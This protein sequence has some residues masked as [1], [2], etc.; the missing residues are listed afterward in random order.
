MIAWEEQELADPELE[1]LRVALLFPKGRERTTESFLGLLR[2]G[3]TSAVCVAFD[4]YRHCEVMTRHGGEN[5]LTV[6]KDEVLE[7]AR[8]ILASATAEEEHSVVALSVLGF[9][10]G[11]QDTELIRAALESAGTEEALI[12]AV[13]AADTIL[14][15]GGSDSTQ[16]KSLTAAVARPAFD[17]NR[18]EAVRWL[19]LNAVA[20]GP[21]L[22]AQEYLLQALELPSITLQAVAGLALAQHDSTAHRPMLEAMVAGWPED[23]DFPA[24]RLLSLL[25]ETA[26]SGD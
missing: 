15:A 2:S 10:A 17:A 16:A 24:D 19:A 3:D 1:S 26:G 25:E 21:P 20:E 18:S 13:R 8:G 23:V 7:R 4:F 14:E 22:L 11:P 12:A 5:S 9:L 6:H